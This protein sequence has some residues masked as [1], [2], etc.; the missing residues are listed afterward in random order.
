MTASFADFGTASLSTVFKTWGR[1]HR[2]WAPNLVFLDE[3]RGAKVIT[4]ASIVAVLK[5]LGIPYEKITVE[6]SVN[7]GRHYVVTLA[8]AMPDPV[9]TVAIQACMGSDLKRETLN[10]A[11][12]RRFRDANEIPATFNIF[13]DAKIDAESRK[14]P[15][16]GKTSK[17]D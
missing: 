10:L 1:I 11:R 2:E 6:R 7:G 5:I 13:Y 8:E 14:A 17:T 9:L 4:R 16:N 12:A 15:E 3:D